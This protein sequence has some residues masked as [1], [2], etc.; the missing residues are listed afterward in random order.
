[1][2]RPSFWLSE[3]PLLLALAGA[4]S[5]PV[6]VTPA[7]AIG[8]LSKVAQFMVLQTLLDSSYEDA[9]ECRMALLMAASTLVPAG[10]PSAMTSSAVGSMSMLKVSSGS[11]SLTTV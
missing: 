8:G 2:P 1:M 3:R 7:S 11:V 6:V 10:R 5:A 4:P 9:A